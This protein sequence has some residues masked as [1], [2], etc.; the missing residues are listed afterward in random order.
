MFLQC[1][2]QEVD[3]AIA[4]VGKARNDMLTHTLIDF[5]MGE[6]DGVPKDPNY[7]YRLYMALG[8]Y[9]QVHGGSFEP[10]HVC[11]ETIFMRNRLEF[12]YTNTTKSVTTREQKNVDGFPSF[13]GVSVA[14]YILLASFFLTK[15]A[16]PHTSYANAGRQNSYYHREAGAGS[17]ELQGESFDVCR[18]KEECRSQPQAPGVNGSTV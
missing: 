15:A 12:L 1:G 17:R 5:L 11:F 10:P 9:S 13:N 8:N 14:W 7:I 2:K 18:G 4:V 3:A 16:C 6:T